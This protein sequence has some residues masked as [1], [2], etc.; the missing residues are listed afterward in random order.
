MKVPRRQGPPRQSSQPTE[1]PAVSEDYDWHGDVVGS[2][3]DSPEAPRQIENIFSSMSVR[4]SGSCPNG[5]GLL[6]T[7]HFT[8]REVEACTAFLVE[9]DV[10]MTSSH[11][12]PTDLRRPG[13][14]GAN[15][16]I[17]KLPFQNQILRVAFVIYS[18]PLNDDE[19]TPDYALLRLKSPAIG[20]PIKVRRH[21]F[22]NRISVEVWRMV[23]D[24]PRSRLLASTQCQ[25]LQNSDLF[26]LFNNSFSPI[27][28][29]THC[30][31]EEGHSGAP[32]LNSQGEAI[33]L[34]DAV[35]ETDRLPISAVMNPHGTKNL[36]VVVLA[37]NL[38]C[39][40]DFKREPT[41]VVPACR[42]DTTGNWLKEEHRR[43]TK[44]TIATQS[45]YLES[46]IQEKIQEWLTKN[47]SVVKWKIEIDKKFD[48]DRDPFITAF[49]PE[50]DC[51]K[52]PPNG[53]QGQQGHA[54]GT[55]YK[56]GIGIGISPEFKFF[57]EA[58][59]IPTDIYEIHFSQNEVRRTGQA[60][61][62]MFQTKQRRAL[63][64]PVCP[65]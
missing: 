31:I 40:Q 58:V 63:T 23:K 39:V 33:G 48:P 59:A 45:P 44:A 55:L 41:P 35:I 64:V 36:P 30:E 50:I 42:T 57:P 9:P 49:R 24:G 11:C 62:L 47:S 6:L 4:C 61:V 46:K 25:T 65:Q 34:I 17:V 38:A 32:V 60:T 15:R 10:L 53:F 43:L 26:P 2:F 56:W 12:V 3:D 14:S 1:F 52:R 13:S 51:I 28:A 27:A 8:Y 21:G 29:I 16:M 5:V 19:L 54:K 18:S 7:T 22:A 20:R 37:T